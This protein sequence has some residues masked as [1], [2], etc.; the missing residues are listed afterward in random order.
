MTE[1]A[2]MKT[3]DDDLHLLVTLAVLTGQRGVNT[4]VGPIYEAWSAAYPEDALG[5]VGKGLALVGAGDLEGGMRM[6]AEAART[7]RTRVR[8]AQDVLRSL[9]A[10]VEAAVG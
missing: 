6:V 1:A 3:F 4:D 7:A 2:T 9:E 10:S 8:Q 5:P